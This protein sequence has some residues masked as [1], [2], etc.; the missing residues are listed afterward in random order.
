MGVYREVKKILLK[1]FS[2]KANFNLHEKVL[3]KKKVILSVLIEKII[4]TG[5]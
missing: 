5:S 4:Q 1:N 3:V 2:I